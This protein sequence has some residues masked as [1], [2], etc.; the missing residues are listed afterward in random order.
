MKATTQRTRPLR[1]TLAL[2]KVDTVALTQHAVI[3]TWSVTVAAATA[4][5]T[6]A[7]TLESSVV[8]RNPRVAVVTMDFSRQLLTRSLNHGPASN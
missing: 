2:I 6:A 5:H 3:T 1:Q 4:W 8:A 7:Q